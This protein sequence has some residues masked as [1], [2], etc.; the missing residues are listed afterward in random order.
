M[1]Q[2]TNIQTSN[3]PK[4][5]DAARETVKYAAQNDGISHDEIKVVREPNAITIELRNKFKVG[6]Y[7]DGWVDIKT[8]KGEL[9]Y[10]ETYFLRALLQNLDSFINDLFNN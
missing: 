1:K 2:R 7:D 4:G 3:T 9:G 8:E 10:H 5:I 6:V